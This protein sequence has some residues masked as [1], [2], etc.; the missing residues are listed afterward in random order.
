METVIMKRREEEEREREDKIYRL[1]EK[2]KG[3][4]GREGGRQKEMNVFPVMRLLL[5]K[6]E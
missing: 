2:E 1:V 3:R 6:T 4:K 5:M